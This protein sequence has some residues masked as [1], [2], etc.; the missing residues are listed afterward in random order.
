MI[1]TGIIPQYKARHILA[2]NVQIDEIDL[3]EE[4]FVWYKNRLFRPQ[5]FLA[6][7]LQMPAQERFKVLTF[8]ERYFRS[9]ESDANELVKV[10][11][12]HVAEEVHLMTK[13]HGGCKVRISGTA[14]VSLHQEQGGL[15]PHEIP[16][17]A[18][19]DRRGYTDEEWRQY[20]SQWTEEEWED[21]RARHTRRHF[22][23]HS[24]RA[25]WG[26]DSNR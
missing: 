18:S 11:F 21:W 24:N 20:N 25:G 22:H 14:L 19:Q 17:F 26:W 12:N 2:V 16:G 4:S 10:F 3:S 1:R 13:D 6:L 8:Y 15:A 23:H 9:E 7:Y 5:Q